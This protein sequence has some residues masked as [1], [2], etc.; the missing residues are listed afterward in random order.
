MDY[1]S[2]SVWRGFASLQ[3]GPEIATWAPK[4]VDSRLAG[5]LLP[6]RLLLAPISLGDAQSLMAARVQGMVNLMQP[7]Q[8]RAALE[9]LLPGDARMALEVPLS[10]VG[11]VLVQ[12]TDPV[13]SGPL[14]DAWGDLTW[15]LT[16]SP[17][18]EAAERRVAGTGLRTWLRLA[19]PPE[20]EGE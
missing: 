8:A 5:L 7:A 10:E 17:A 1:G 19:M 6:R 16:A 12:Q 11:E 13:M 14:G 15:P 2:H 18:T 20:P 4:G 3:P 9:A